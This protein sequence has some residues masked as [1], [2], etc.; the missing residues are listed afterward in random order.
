MGP[1]LSGQGEGERAPGGVSLL[2]R[3]PSPC[4]CRRKS[5]SGL[6]PV[7][8]A[9]C[10]S[11]QSFKYLRCCVSQGAGS[12]AGLWVPAACCLLGVHWWY[13]A[14]ISLNLKY[15]CDRGREDS[16][17]FG[18]KFTGENSTY[19]ALYASGQYLARKPLSSGSIHPLSWKKIADVHV[20]KCCKSHPAFRQQAS[21]L[22]SGSSWGGF[23]RRDVLCCLLVLFWAGPVASPLLQDPGT[24]LG[25]SPLLPTISSWSETW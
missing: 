14:L 23:S 7:T 20:L 16:I 11:G 5:L 24:S 3:T 2:D 6:C 1:A 17:G 8:L 4:V 12:C 21:E 22:R 25:R 10:F 9:H 19:G 15:Q 18:S 13:T